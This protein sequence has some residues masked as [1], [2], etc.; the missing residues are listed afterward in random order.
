MKK[1]K[2]NEYF[3]KELQFL[4]F[5]YEACDS[6]CFDIETRVLSPLLLCNHPF[7]WNFN[8]LALVISFTAPRY[9]ERVIWNKQTCSG[10]DAARRPTSDG[11]SGVCDRAGC[12][13]MPCMATEMFMRRLIFDRQKLLC[14]VQGCF[15]SVFV[16][17]GRLANVF[18]GSSSEIHQKCL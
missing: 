5:V 8:Y 10:K 16:F 13:L 1:L 4:V 2:R 6:C 12:R 3:W 14:L 15:F 18:A 17:F 7:L 9:Q 11:E